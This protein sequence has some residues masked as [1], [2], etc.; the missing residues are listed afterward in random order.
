MHRLFS[1]LKSPVVRRFSSHSSQASL[2]PLII[3][4]KPVPEP[5]ERY[6]PGGYHPVKVGDVCNQRYRAVRQLG[7]G[8]YS[9]VW[10]IEDIK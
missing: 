5:S 10:Q 4:R 6:E 1:S 2:F 9:T 7:W 3:T 8:L